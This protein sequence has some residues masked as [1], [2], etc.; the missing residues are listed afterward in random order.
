MTATANVL[1]EGFSRL[2]RGRLRGVWVRGM[3]PP[4][5]VVWAANHHS[6]WDPFV[7]DVVI[8]NA[9]RTAGLVMD[10]DN[11]ERFRFLRGLDVVG[12][13][14]PRRALGL[15]ES[16]NVLVI[17]PEGEL[18]PVGPVRPLARGAAWL[19]QQAQAHLVAVGIRVVVRGHEAPE[20]YVALQKVSGWHRI[21]DPT[22]LLQATLAAELADIDKINGTADPRLPLPGF[23]LVVSGRRSWDERLT[24]LAT[25]GRRAG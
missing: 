16:G 3:L 13:R 5:P 17:Y 15:L 7:A 19:A 22:P 23:A 18:R 2:V 10:D 21:D 14:E 12:T 4:G 1:H 24:R 9:G 6:W 25:R 20:A 8:R 11:L